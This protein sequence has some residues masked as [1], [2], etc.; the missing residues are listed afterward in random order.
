MT[1]SPS[2]PEIEFLYEQGPVMVVNKPAGLLTQAPPEIDSMELR[3]K[4]FL[5]IRENKPGN[6]YLGVPHRL[7]RPV[8]GAMVFA[9]HVRATRGLS[10]Q[11]E[12]RAVQKKYWAITE[13]RPPEPSGEWMD[14]M[15]KIPGKAQSEIVDEQH[16]HA[17]LA[18]L[19]YRCIQEFKSP[20]SLL[21]ITLETG[22]T[23]QIRLQC[24]SRNL[25]IVGDF[26]YQATSNFGE[27]QPDER[28]RQIALHARFLKFQHPMT[29]ELLSHIAP[30]SGPWNQYPITIDS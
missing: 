8:S 30:L 7:D 6:V 17:R 2:L 28:K 23:H 4:R 29:R 21:E 26:Q 5:K 12:Y 3:L 16:P 1:A 22:R 27:P 20:H 25:P 19:K 10:E 11:F 13:G 15:R 9:K 18:I 14:Y 24:S